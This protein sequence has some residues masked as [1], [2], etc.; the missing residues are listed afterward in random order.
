MVQV[1]TICYTDAFVGLLHRN[2]KPNDVHA[3]RCRQPER[4][5]TP[6]QGCAIDSRGNRSKGK[7]PR[8]ITFPEFTP[9]LDWYTCFQGNG[10]EGELIDC[11][12]GALNKPYDQSFV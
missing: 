1:T 3:V 5:E 9:D 11:N 7:A 6:S 2:K 8:V 12:E 10:V 4:G